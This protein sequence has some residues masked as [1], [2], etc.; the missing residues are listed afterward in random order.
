MRRVFYGTAMV[1]MLAFL[2]AFATAPSVAK[3][4]N[5]LIQQAATKIENKD[6][7]QNSGPG[8]F[9]GEAQA[10]PNQSPMGNSVIDCQ[11]AMLGKFCALPGW[12]LGNQGATNNRYNLGHE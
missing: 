10:G 6:A 2:V 4:S 12:A 1:C 3:A 7:T 5:Q 8:Q 9:S 11:R